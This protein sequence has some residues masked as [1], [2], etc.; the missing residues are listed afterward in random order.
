MSRLTSADQILQRMYQ[1]ILNGD[2]SFEI[3]RSRSGK[4]ILCVP[5][6]QAN[7]QKLCV[8]TYS[9]NGIIERLK[10]RLARTGGLHDWNLCNQLAHAGVSVPHPMGCGRW[11]A[12][13]RLPRKTLFAQQ[14]V[15]DGQPMS[16]LMR[17]KK[18]AGSIS[19]PWLHRLL[20]SIGRFVAVIHQKGFFPRDLH[21]GNLML[22][23]P[24]SGDIGLSLI[25]YESIHRRHPYRKNKAHLNLGHICSYFNAFLPDAHQRLAE[26]YCRVWLRKTPPNLATKISDV[27]HEHNRWR[28]KRIDLAFERIEIA[29]RK[30]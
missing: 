14:W 25:D 26:A 20:E 12:R 8:K 18:E 9:H 4:Q 28:K 17:R 16:Q 21:P 19:E 5:A 10:A 23:E 27:A 13:A 29:R 1:Q 11:P 7:G 3:V 24:L 2:H 6:A 15:E 22:H 30:V